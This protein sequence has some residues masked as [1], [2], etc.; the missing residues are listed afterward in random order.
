MTPTRRDEFDAM[1]DMSRMRCAPKDASGVSYD[2][3][4]TLYRLVRDKGLSNTLEVGLGGGLSA[5][6]MCAAHA[7]KGTGSHIAI[8]PFQF[9]SFEG[10]G[11]QRL[12]RAGLDSHFQHIAEHLGSPCPSWSLPVVDLTASLSTVGMSLTT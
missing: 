12:E 2:G 6:F 3:G 9:S 4:Q 7:E 10:A 1:Y 8:D 5:F 11:I